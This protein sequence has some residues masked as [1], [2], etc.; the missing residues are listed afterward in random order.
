MPRK[1]KP[2]PTF[3]LD[4]SLGGKLVAQALRA[5]GATVVLH[6]D[7]FV[8]GTPDTEWLAEAGR[9][10]WIVLT[11]DE[12]IRR[13]PLEKQMFRDFHVR[14]FVLT[15]KNLRGDEM[16]SIFARALPRMLK[17]AHGVPAPFMFSIAQSG[18]FT[19]LE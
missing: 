15:R 2:E 18:A 8:P 9:R 6:D 12:A 19:R 7:A 3:F 17:R 1:R 4:A 13:N 10:G 11:K 16:A 14:V 5:A